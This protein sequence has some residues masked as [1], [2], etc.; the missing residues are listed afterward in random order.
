MTSD[1]HPDP[2]LDEDFLEREGLDEATVEAVGK[3]S[4]AFEA[5]QAARGHLYQFHR[6]TGRSDLLLGD[7]VEALRSAGHRDLAERIDAEL[8]GRNV[9]AGRW[10]FQ[11]I[12]EYDDDYHRLFRELDEEGTRLV[13]GHRH[14]FEAGLKRD[15]RTA[16]HEGHEATPEEAGLSRADD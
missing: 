14:L 16:G 13:K 1:N 7:A 8:L 10:T 4:E 5:A 12:E 11:I 6:L 9:L 2:R 15:R 3:L